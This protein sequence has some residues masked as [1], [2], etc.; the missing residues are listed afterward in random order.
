MISRVEWISFLVAIV[1]GFA[2]VLLVRARRP[3]PA[4]K[5]DAWAER[6]GLELD[7]GERKRVAAYL[8]RGRWWRTVGGTVPWLALTLL[9]VIAAAA[10]DRQVEGSVRLAWLLIP[11]GYLTAAVLAEATASRPRPG[12][13]GAALTPRT[14]DGYL[15]R[16]VLAVLRVTA[17]GVAAT[18]VIVLVM[19]IKPEGWVRHSAAALVTAG[20][21]VVMAVVVEVVLRRVVALPQPAVSDRALALDTALRSASIRTIAGAGIALLLHL[22]ATQVVRLGAANVP[23]TA[24][25]ALFLL[26]PVLEGLAIGSWRDM[27]R[28]GPHSGRARETAGPVA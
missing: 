7:D 2:G 18:G 27:A 15:P 5:V 14:L 26:S 4:A 24:T 20:I 6:F 1:T 25:F 10:F 28:S 17:L 9:D 13:A 3:L 12:A 21:A 22:L 16:W 19:P 11:A 23:G 8:R